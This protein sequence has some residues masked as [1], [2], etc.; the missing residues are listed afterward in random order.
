MSL[1]RILRTIGLEIYKFTKTAAPGV[2]LGDVDTRSNRVA[3]RSRVPGAAS[4]P[5]CMAPTS[6]Q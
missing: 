4:E 1:A 3:R 6:G 2:T 5:H